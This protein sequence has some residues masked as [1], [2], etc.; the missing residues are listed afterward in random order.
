MIYT[1]FISLSCL[2]ITNFKL[3][4]FEST[5]TKQFCIWPTPYLNRTINKTYFS[6][7]LRSNYFVMHLYSKQKYEVK[8]QYSAMQRKSRSYSDK[9]ARK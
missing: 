3:T 5:K 1:L 8:V 2:F 6:H 7:H 4:L 9:A